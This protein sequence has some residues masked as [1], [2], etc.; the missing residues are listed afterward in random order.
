[1]QFQHLQRLIDQISQI[2]IVLLGIVDLIAAVYYSAQNIH[3]N[4]SYWK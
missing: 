2:Q 3:F 4:G 1:M